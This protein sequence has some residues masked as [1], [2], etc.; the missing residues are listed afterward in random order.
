MLV[1]HLL[2]EKYG[3]DV[4]E[5]I[6]VCNSHPRVNII[7]PGPGVGGPCLPKD[8]YLLLNP[9][10]LPPVT[11][12]LISNSRKTNDGMPQHVVNIV[13]KAL[14][15]KNLEISK[16]TILILG[17]AYKANVSET[18][19]SPAKKIISDLI[20]RGTK[21]LV[22]DPHTDESFGGEKISNVWEGISSSDAVLLV[23]DHSEFKKLD[24]SKIKQNMK[25]P[26][27][28]DTRRLFDS[29]KAEQMGIHYFSVG[30]SKNYEIT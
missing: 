10:G 6:Q 29:K 15:S 2:C 7:K 17:T 26:I 8:P 23:T 28:I 27:L 18:R 1:L 21:V 3:I 14:R 4:S 13:E 25:N 16:S 20:V 12:T 22:F 30:Y 19:L 9:Q 5:L 24:L 11:S